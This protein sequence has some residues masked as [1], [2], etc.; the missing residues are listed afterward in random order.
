MRLVKLAV[1]LLLPPMQF[2]RLPRSSR[3]SLFCQNGGFC[4]QIGQNAKTFLGA[5][6]TSVRK[7]E[8][9]GA[10]PGLHAAFERLPKALRAARADAWFY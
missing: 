2:Y 4:H 5:V 3:F 6:M 1:Q 8:K 7:G 9:E 10:G